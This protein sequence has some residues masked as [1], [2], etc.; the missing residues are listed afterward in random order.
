MEQATADFKN[1]TVI[2]TGGT[3]GIG[4]AV[5]EAFLDAGATVIATY[6]SNRAAAE[7]FRETRTADPLHLRQFDI[8]QADEV[9]RFY[10]DVEEAHG[11]FEVLVNNSGIRRDAVV[12]LMRE[13]DWRDVID[14]NL[15]G[16]FLMCKQAVQSLMRQRYGRIVTITSPIGKFGFAGQANYAASKAGQVA[17]TKSLSK[18]VAKRGITVNCVSPGFVDTD[19][20]ADLPEKQ[21]DAYLGMVPVKRFGKPEEVARAVLFLAARESAYINGAVLEVTGGL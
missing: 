7:A 4:R 14:T 20:I 1:Q 17:L 5:A 18:E 11:A 9:E 10:R 15:T 8:A 12:G 21:R 2:V 13:S 6:K 3:R 19:F 16:T